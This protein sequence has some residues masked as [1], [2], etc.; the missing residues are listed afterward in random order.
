MMWS[1]IK[2]YLRK[3]KARTKTALEI[4]IAEALN[5]ITVSDI[6]AWFEENGYSKQ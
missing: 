3:E 6:V 5:S 2:A 1:K 4:A